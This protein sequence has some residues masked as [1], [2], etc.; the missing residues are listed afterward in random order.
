MAAGHAIV[1][2]AGGIVTTPDGAAL[3][4]GDAPDF[5]IPGFIAWGDPGAV[6]EALKRRS[7]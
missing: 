2:A 6:E 1:A 4:Y 3:T 5:H 7:A